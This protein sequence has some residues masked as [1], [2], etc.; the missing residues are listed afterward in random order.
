[1][2]YA[3]KMPALSTLLDPL[4]Q[5]LLCLVAFIDSVDAVIV[6]SALPSIQR[7]L[8][9]SEQGLQ[10]VN[11]GYLLPYAG[12]MLLGGRLADLL[13]RRRVLVV[14]VLVFGCASLIGG[15]APAAPVLVGARIIQGVGAAAMLPSAFSLLIELFKGDNRSRALGRWGGVIGLASMFGVVLGG[16]LT[17]LLNWRWVLLINPVIC[18]VI[19][20]GI[21]LVLPNDRRHAPWASFD[22]PGAVLGTGG[23]L[24]LVF[25]V[26]EAPQAG[27]LSWRTAVCLALALALLGGFVWNEHRCARTGSTAPL[28]PLSLFRISGLAAANAV[29]LLAIG[30]MYAMFYILTLYMQSVLHYSPLMAGLAYLPATVSLG[31]TALVATRLI[32]RIGTLPLIIGG[33]AVASFGVYLLSH[34]PVQGDYAAHLLPGLLFM[35]VGL[36]AVVAAVPNAATAGAPVAD[37]GVAA[38]LPLTATQAGGAL[39][40]AV[41]GTVAASYTTHLLAAGMSTPAALTAG[42][43]RA[44]LAAAAVILVAAVVG[45][46]TKNTR[47]EAAQPA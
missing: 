19:L 17:D 9:F 14:G 15:L 10:W 16:L 40:I 5:T 27:W 23:M 11:T 35:S 28:L 43:N 38:S 42:F 7:Q 41:L 13:G 20:I 44:L 22:L 4:R 3:V 21:F 37:S 32:P 45:L 33:P 36:G 34:L 26:V 29:Q 31:V 30:G 12:G 18:A 1:M 46:R 8:G 2:K 25:A 24:L 6:N 47:D 39:G